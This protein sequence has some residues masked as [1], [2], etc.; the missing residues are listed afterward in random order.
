M[1][2]C[3][4]TGNVGNHQFFYAFTRVVAETLGY[5]FGFNPIPSHDYFNGQEQMAFMEIDYGIKHNAK[6]GE[7]PDGIKNVWREKYENIPNSNGAS[8]HPYQPEVFEVEDNTKLILRCVQDARYFENKKNEMRD[9]FRIRPEKEKEFESVLNSYNINL[10]GNLVVLNIRGGEY[11]GISSLILQ[12]KYWQDAINIM[13]KRNSKYKFLAVTD[14][15][16]YTN[17]LL[18][19]KIPVIHNSIGCDYYVI[20]KA[21]NLIISNSSFAILPT[22]LNENHPNV[23]A[24]KYWARHNISDGYWASSNVWTFGLDDEWCFLGRDGVCNA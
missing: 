8:F 4:L 22:W 5:K 16:T 6:Y 11:K 21:K 20:N 7:M 24:P 18:D 9:W 2:T 13:K 12:K 23:I 1:I 17:I 14:D 19:H 3:D 15:V 10:D